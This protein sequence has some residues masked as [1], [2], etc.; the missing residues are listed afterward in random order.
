[1]FQDSEDVDGCQSATARLWGN[2]IT[3]DARF[4]GRSVRSF[5]CALRLGACPANILLMYSAAYLLLSP[6][7]PYT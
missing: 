6:S 7:G 5:E 4:P 3:V 1:M 2:G